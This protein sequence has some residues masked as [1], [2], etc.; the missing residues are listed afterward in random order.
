MSYCRASNSP[1]YIYP[2][3]DGI[4]FVGSGTISDDEIDLFLY[5]LSSRPDEL[6]MRI[7]HG[8]QVIRDYLNFLKEDDPEAYEFAVLGNQ[9]LIR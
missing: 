4:V 9:E 1:F 3:S 7:E 6:N 2:S 5:K 8:K